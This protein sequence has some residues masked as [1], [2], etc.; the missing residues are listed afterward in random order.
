MGED[1]KEEIKAMRERVIGSVVDLYCSPHTDVRDWDYTGLENELRRF[2]LKQIAPGRYEPLFPEGRPSPKDLRNYILDRAERAYEEKEAEFTDAPLSMRDLERMLLLSSVDNKWMAHID[3]MDQ[4]K[5]GIGLRA[6]GQTSP[7]VAFR[8]ESFDLFD[9]MITSIETDT[10]RNLYHVR[11]N[12]RI[13][14]KE[15]RIT[16]ESSA[17]NTAPATTVKRAKKIGRNDPCPCGSGKKYKDCHGRPGAP[18]LN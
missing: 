8:K 16:S 13:E 12:T 3:D 14:Q 9:E 15:R 4:L 6:Y 7:V 11:L 5:Q 17:G 1:L 2:F 10:I 18:A